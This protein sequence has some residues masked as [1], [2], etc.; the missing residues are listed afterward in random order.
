MRS[1]WHN[2]RRLTLKKIGALITPSQTQQPSPHPATYLAQLHPEIQASLSPQQRADIERVIALAIPKPAPKLVDL[3]FA[4]DLVVSRFFVVLM[5]GKDRRR[6]QRERP[7]TRM[8]QLGNWAMAVV[9]LLGFN[10][11]ISTS[12][13]MLAYL[14][15]S[16]L[17]I[18]LLPGHFRGFGN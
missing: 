1:Y 10:L 18:D 9:L 11:A 3:R 7:V 17:G 4:I 8:T 15:K 16:A 14:I 2:L 12:I 6:A 5:V 13:L